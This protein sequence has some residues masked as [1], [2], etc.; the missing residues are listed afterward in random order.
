VAASDARAE[1]RAETAPS[2]AASAPFWACRADASAARAPARLDGWCGGRA[3][4]APPP[5]PP[6]A[7]AAPGRQ[8]QHAGLARPG[9]APDA[10][11]ERGGLEQ[12][13]AAH[14]EE[15]APV[16]AGRAGAGERGRGRG[17]GRGRSCRGFASGGGGRR[18][19]RPSPTGPAGRDAAGPVGGV[20]G[21]P[22]GRL[23]GWGEG[24]RVVEWWWWWRDEACEFLF[25]RNEEAPPER[26][27]SPFPSTQLT[28][29]TQLVSMP[30][31][32]RGVTIWGAGVW[33]AVAWTSRPRASGAGVRAGAWHAASALPAAAAA[34]AATVAALAAVGRREG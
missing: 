20:G 31:A 25:Y 10:R 2:A 27:F 30:R 26:S 4:A 23:W 8:Q 9:R 32:H 6:P 3:A 34:G 13:A 21:Q 5:P 22:A 33:R 17:R 15:V 7:A 14:K 16:V 12:A 28:L 1:A 19:G 29:S 24:E 11:R 18:G